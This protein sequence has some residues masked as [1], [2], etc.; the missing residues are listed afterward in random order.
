MSVDAWKIRRLKIAEKQGKLE[1]D[2]TYDGLDKWWTTECEKC[3]DKWIIGEDEICARG[4]AWKILYRNMPDGTTH[5][6]R[7]CNYP[8]Q[9]R[10]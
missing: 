3:P 9:G 8:V 2:N 1:K 7:K 4:V 6:P 10:L 5:L